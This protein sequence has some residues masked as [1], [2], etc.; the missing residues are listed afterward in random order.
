MSDDRQGRNGGRHPRMIV[1][2]RAALLANSAALGG[3]PGIP[4]PEIGDDPAAI[5]WGSAS[6]I[7]H[8]TNGDTTV[9]APAAVMRK[10]FTVS[11]DVESAVLQVTALGAYEAQING[12]RV[13]DRELTPGWT[14]YNVRRQ[15]Q[16]YNV[17]SMIVPG[18]N[19]VGVE[20]GDG[21]AH[22]NLSLLG[23]N[24]YGNDV[25]RALVALRLEYTD[26]TGETIVSDTSWKATTSDNLSNDLY[27]GSVH[28]ARLKKDWSNPATSDAGWATPSSIAKGSV[29]YVKQPSPPTR[30]KEALAPIALTSPSAGIYI[31][32]FGQNHA[33]FCKLTVAGASSG[34]SIQLRHAEYLN[35]D[36]TLYVANLRTAEATDTFIC[37]G[38][39]TEVFEPRHTYHGY[40]YVEVT[41]FP[42]APP[43]DCLTSYFIYQD[44]AFVSTFNSSSM[45]LNKIWDAS[46][47]SWKSNSQTIPTDC[48]QR[49][50]R[51]GWTADAQLFCSTALYLQD[52][53][54]FWSK[55]AYDVHDTAISGM[56]GDVAP[57]VSIVGRGHTGWG[58]AGI[59]IP[60]TLWQH[61]GET[62]YLS[63]HWSGMISMLD[64]LPYTNAYNDHLHV[65][66]PS[67]NDLLAYAMAY[68]AATMMQEAATAL[69][70]SVVAA[71]AEAKMASFS[72]S[73]NTLVSNGGATIGNNSQTSYVLALAFGLL[74]EG[75]RAV[76]AETL[77]TK[78][79]VN[80]LTCGFIGLAYV[81]D[82]LADNGYLSL[83]YTL[84]E[85]TTNRSLGYQ[86][87]TSDMTTLGEL[88]DPAGARGVNDDANSMNHF[89]RGSV[90]GWMARAV[91]GIEAYAPGFA[92]VLLRP[93]PGGT[94]TSAELSFDSPAGQI[95]TVWSISG[96]TLTWTFTTPVAA[97]VSLPLYY[98]L[99]SAFAGSTPTTADP[100]TGGY[101]YTV[102]AGTYTLTAEYVAP[103]LPT[104]WAREDGVNRSSFVDTTLSNL[105]A[106]GTFGTGNWRGIRSTD[107]APRTTATYRAEFTISWVT[108]SHFT[109]G[110]EPGEADFSDTP[111]PFGIAGAKFYYNNGAGTQT[112]MIS[113][114]PGEQNLGS[115]SGNTEVGDI[116]VMDI[117]Q[118][119]E[120]DAATVQ[121]KRRRAGVTTD[122][123]T[124]A[125]IALPEGGFYAFASMFNDWAVTANFSGP[126]DSG[127][128]GVIPFQGA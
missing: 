98:S 109:L 3:T 96:P 72:A 5:S 42:G 16:T 11:K 45:V 54:A 119:A 94:V 2:L 92:T 102:P 93:R 36:G 49:D 128:D 7:G 83:A 111:D 70:D 110:I 79:N 78:I 59:I 85:K 103:A 9:S 21:W 63:D 71:S 53:G 84:L 108:D 39:G 23:R 124:P 125:A 91:A 76:A 69:G 48:N 97:Y 81:Y 30:R 55:Y 95:T 90:A 18:A 73:F 20:V 65:S 115:A 17:T 82:V 6:L 28:D 33:G 74:P 101:R 46:V 80:G 107:P 13:G 25:P 50:E 38:T 1:R 117:V 113:P 27:N 67:D 62:D 34:T 51:M 88:W 29:P 41:G 75:Q 120:A 31:F 105:K 8:N 87:I 19:A 86:L 61:Y 122:L 32:D 14:D 44:A 57:Y 126:F 26:G 114:G 123:G 127:D 112:H 118:D 77:A 100:V 89:V 56:I 12:D 24:Y 40:R 99:S 15:F 64:A 68:R 121:F 60:W 106:Q 4:A 10:T 104:S 58:E 43:M 47:A 116:I 66:D 52:G 37:A 35:D 22:G